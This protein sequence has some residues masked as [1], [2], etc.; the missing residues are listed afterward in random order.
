[1]QSNISQ[2]AKQIEDYSKPVI[3]YNVLKASQE[4]IRKNHLR[5]S[6]RLAIAALSYCNKKDTE[7]L[8]EKYDMSKVVFD[9]ANYAF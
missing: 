5:P 4:K 2:F 3:R 8:A 9:Y 1:T 7:E 6:E